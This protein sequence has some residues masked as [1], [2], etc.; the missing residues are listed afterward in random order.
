MSDPTLREL[1]EILSDPGVEDF[2]S[3]YGNATPPEFA[4]EDT[5]AIETAAKPL[6]RRWVPSLTSLAVSRKLRDAKQASGA[7]KPT[8]GGAR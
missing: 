4:S 5:E 7:K 6:A 3:L 2:D 8:K 1:R